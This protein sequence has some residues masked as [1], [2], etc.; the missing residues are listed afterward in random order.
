ME[1][2]TDFPRPPQGYD[3]IWVV[4]DRLM[5]SAYFVP[6]RI[7]Y[8]MDKLAQLYLQEI[9]QIHEVLE[10]IMSNRD[11]RFQSRF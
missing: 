7:N 6:I 8:S 4:V 10:T 3:V 5:K 11:P 2:I 9:V 1:I